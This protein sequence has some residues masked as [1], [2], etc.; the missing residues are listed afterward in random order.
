MT[1]RPRWFDPY[2]TALG[3]TIGRAVRAF[4]LTDAVMPH[5]ARLLRR[6]AP[7]HP[8]LSLVPAPQRDAEPPRPPSC[9][10]ATLREPWR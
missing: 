10:A 4:G 1:T 6:L 2:A 8:A 3:R 9:A 5:L 7:D